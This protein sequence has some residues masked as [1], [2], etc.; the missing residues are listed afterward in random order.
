VKIEPKNL[1]KFMAAERERQGL[2][3]RELAKA[4]GSPN[5]PRAWAQ[6]EDGKISPRLETVEKLL[7]A[8]GY[9]LTLEITKK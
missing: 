4:L 7:R 9:T 1:G 5:S 3:F 6:Y 8:V 2:T